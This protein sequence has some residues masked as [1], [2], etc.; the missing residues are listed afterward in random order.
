MAH[1]Y[2]CSLSS[3]VRNARHHT[4]KNVLYKAAKKGMMAP[5]LEPQMELQNVTMG[6]TDIC[7]TDGMQVG[8]MHLYVVVV[9][10]I[11][12]SCQDEEGKLPR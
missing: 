12:A 2:T 5:Q 10:P 11:Q 9:A 6:R 1:N 8:A 4:I 7:L 3:K